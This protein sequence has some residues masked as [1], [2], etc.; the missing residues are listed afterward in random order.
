MIA[1]SL[2]LRPYWKFSLLSTIDAV[3]NNGAILSLER[4]STQIGTL[5]VEILYFFMTYMPQRDQV[6]KLRNLISNINQS[7]TVTSVLQV[8]CFAHLVVSEHCHAM[9]QL[10]QSTNKT[11][12]F[13]T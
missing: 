8:F 13:L 10:E 1:F 7:L 12:Q 5:V 2:F 11:G 9:G 6:E 4:I 3:G